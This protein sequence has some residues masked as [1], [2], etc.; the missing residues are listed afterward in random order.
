MSVETCEWGHDDCKNL[1]LKC[2]LCISDSFHY[3]PVRTKR[4]KPL[5][6]RQPKQDRRQGSYFEYRNHLKNEAAIEHAVSSKM[7]PN[8]GAGPIKGDEQIRGLI[9]IM[10]ELKTKTT[11]QARGKKSFTI[12]KEWLDKL[13]KEANQ[14]GMEF[15]YL[16]FS[17]NEYDSD[18]Y[19]IV[20]E[21]V[22]MSMVATIIEDRAKAKRMELEED[23]Y[24]KRIRHLEAKNI[25]LQ[26]KID[27]LEAELQ[28]H[29]N[30]K[31]GDI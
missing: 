29:K 7:T 2:H 23:V 5:A 13:N 18:V 1:G 26:A 14:S 24:K 15:W 3:V 9:N 21:D 17:F 6:R 19:V 25:E 16:K 11:E 8:S 28:L 20:E 12:K 10:E 31:D 4:A 30:A 27:L 22:I